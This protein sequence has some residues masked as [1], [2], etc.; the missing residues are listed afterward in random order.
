MRRSRSSAPTEAV[1]LDVALRAATVGPWLTTR[2]PVGGRL[3]V[4]APADLVVLPIDLAAGAAPDIE[5][6]RALRPLLTL[7]DGQERHRAA[8]FDR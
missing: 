8:D 6:V 2:D 1:G 4:G 7:I 3:V 5:A